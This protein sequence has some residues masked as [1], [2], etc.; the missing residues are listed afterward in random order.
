[1][2]NLCKK[3]R[4]YLSKTIYYSP[5]NKS[6]KKNRKIRN[7]RTKDIRKIKNFKIQKAGNI[8]N[9]LKDIPDRL[10]KIPK[11]LRTMVGKISEKT[12]ITKP[13]NDNS[14]NSLNNSSN[15]SSKNNNSNN[16]SSKNNNSSNDSKSNWK[17]WLLW[18][19]TPRPFEMLDNP[20]RNHG[21]I[22]KKG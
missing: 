12:K 19:V 10:K 5:L 3:G 15:N 1:M 21:T 9:K 2:I 14:N 22:W 13:V 11:T 16:N 4:S 8:K 6:L 18:G 20:V 17:K 7:T